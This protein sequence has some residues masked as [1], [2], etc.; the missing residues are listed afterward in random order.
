MIDERARQ[1]RA[2]TTRWSTAPC[3]P[4]VQ[5]PTLLS[6]RCVLLSEKGILCVTLRQRLRRKEAGFLPPLALH[7]KNPRRSSKRP[8]DTFHLSSGSPRSRLTFLF[9]APRVA[10]YF[11]CCSTLL[12]APCIPQRQAGARAY[13]RLI[14]SRAAPLTSRS[15]PPYTHSLAPRVFSLHPASHA[16][17][18]RSHSPAQL[19]RE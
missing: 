19:P 6:L 5:P 15:T 2:L 16:G 8:A 14:K 3:D 11:F 9:F 12:R 7:T 1:C 13:Q 17:S 18:L 10:V 4:A